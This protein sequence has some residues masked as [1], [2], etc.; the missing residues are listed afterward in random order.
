M[1]AYKV[2]NRIMN[3]KNIS[4]DEWL[5]LQMEIREFLKTDPPEEEKSLFYPLDNMK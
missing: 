4:D 1:E 2:A 5:Q 3:D